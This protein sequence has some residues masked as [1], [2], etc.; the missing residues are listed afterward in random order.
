LEKLKA[1]NYVAKTGN[2]SHAAPYL[3]LNQSSFSRNITGLKKHLGYS[4][5]IRNRNGVTLTRK[6]EE[7]LRVTE[8]IILNVKKFASRTYAPTQF[9]NKRK[10]TIAASQALAA[11]L[12][13]N[14]ILTYHEEHSDLIFE[15]IG[16]DDVLDI[17][18]N[19][20][21]ISIWPDDLKASQAEYVTW[22]IV[23]EPYMMLEKN[24]MQALDI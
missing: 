12:I 24:Y 13:N 16:I 23:Q 2:I 6:G 15:V 19:D 1:F 9:G 7:L 11:Y 10:I 3:N 4:L 21:D 18:L 5:F 14:H 22:K 8:S 20:V 17:V